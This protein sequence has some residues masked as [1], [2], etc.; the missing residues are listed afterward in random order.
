MESITYPSSLVQLF[1]FVF[2][3]LGNLTYNE[4]L[5]WKC[6]GLNKNL[7]KYLIVNEF[8]KK[9]GKRSQR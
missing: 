6:F 4:I 3:I 8:K 2:L 5:E 7:K 9:R 1:G